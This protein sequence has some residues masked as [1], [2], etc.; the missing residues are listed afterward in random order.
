MTCQIT[1]FPFGEK[2]TIKEVESVLELLMTFNVKADVH[3]MSTTVTG[4]E[5]EIFKMIRKVYDQL[6]E[7]E[8]LFRL[9][10]EMLH[11]PEK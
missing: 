3:E 11:I 10:V 9:H 7:K 1:Y 4:E 8:K 5:D 6:S 2:D